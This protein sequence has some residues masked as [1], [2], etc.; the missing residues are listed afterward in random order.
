MG[1]TWSALADL[2][3]VA[4][5]L[6]RIWAVSGQLAWL[7]SRRYLLQ[8]RELDMAVRFTG[9]KGDLELFDVPDEE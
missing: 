3:W 9:I 5:G 2:Y 6:W 4:L 8:C 1:R 7:T